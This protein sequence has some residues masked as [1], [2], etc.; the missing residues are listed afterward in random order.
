MKA[1][2]RTF[3]F[4]F[5]IGARFLKWKRPEIIKGEGALKNVPEILLKEGKK[6]PLIVCGPHIR[7]SLVP[8]LLSYLDEKKISYEI[9]KD[10]EADPK[11]STAEKIKELYLCK[12][13]DSFILFGGGSPMDAGKAAASL[14]ACPKKKV[15]DLQGLLKVN[16]KLPLMIAVPT[17]AGTGSETTI[18]AVI[19]DDSTGRK[20]AIMDLRIVPSYAVLDPGLTIGLSPK[21]TAETG[22]DALTH[23]VEAY[24][25]WTYNTEE[26]LRE[27][28]DAVKLI[29]EN[30]EK[31]YLNGT[32][33]S[34]REN[35][36]QASLKAGFAFTR[37]GVGY[38]HAIA[39]TLGGLYH[40]PHG[41]AN[42][43]LLPVV[44]RD[45]GKAVYPK[46]SRLAE[47]TGISGNTE[48]ERAL[49]FISHI[50]E[51]GKRMNIPECFS[52][53]DER[54]YDTICTW[55]LK[56]A[57]PVYP[58]PVIYDRNRIVSILEK[59]RKKG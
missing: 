17:T 35:M 15:K 55:A 25:C 7:L 22:M 56:E 45:Y 16:G 39:H 2:I 58:V 59:V 24:I 52:E 51:M 29:F 36:L 54:D 32:D 6:K 12:K 8:E 41:R 43:V 19:T 28:E 44:L 42:A 10:V 9:Y 14:I 40:I 11:S 13:C 1:Y 23:A 3:Q 31:A 38:V 49:N 27:A 33:I 5:N 46:L 30:L 57:N 4:V 20:K 21:T 53:I 34:A 37:A 48:E 26:S 18:A 47:I 50:E